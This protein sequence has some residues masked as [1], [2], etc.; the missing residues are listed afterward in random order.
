MDAQ[1]LQSEFGSEA[2]LDR[3]WLAHLDC[4]GTM[5]G[6]GI[7]RKGTEAESLQ[8]AWSLAQALASWLLRNAAG[9]PSNER[10]SVVVGWS[11]ATRP[12]QGQ[13]FK[14][15][16]LVEDL[17]RIVASPTYEEFSSSCLQPNWQRDVF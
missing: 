15:G 13:I 14:L 12:A 17:R 8:G 2:V 6:A 11:R 3:L 7:T 5:I 10:Y 4:Y 1:A 16:G 9:R